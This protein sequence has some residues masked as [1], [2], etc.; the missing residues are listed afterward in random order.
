MKIINSSCQLQKKKKK[1]LAGRKIGRGFIISLCMKL[2]LTNHRCSS[3]FL[4][5]G[6]K[7]Y[8]YIF[9]KMLGR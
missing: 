7:K 4:N 5:V 6:N 1:K 3:Y 9:I 8:V 2:S